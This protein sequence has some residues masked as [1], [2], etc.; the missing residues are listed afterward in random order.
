MHCKAWQS[1]H[2]NAACAAELYCKRAVL[3]LASQERHGN[4]LCS[5][6]AA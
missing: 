1:L 3:G 5:H 4:A 6:D 2:S